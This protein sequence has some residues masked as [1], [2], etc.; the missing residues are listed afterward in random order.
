MNAITREEFPS[1]L[2]IAG[3]KLR[4]KR[5]L[6]FVPEK[7]EQWQDRDFIAVMN[8]SKTEGVIVAELDKMY[9][10]PFR[11]QKRT[12]NRMGRVEAI[13]CDICATWQR[14]STSAVISFSKEKGS[15]SFLCC[16]DLLCS[17]HV[18]DK[19]SVSKLSRVQLRETISPSQRIARLKER[20][21]SIFRE[22]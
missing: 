18:R 10:V 22:F 8:R 6:R 5:E 21:Q 11:L 16:G 1:L 12:A 19:T 17:L 14:G 9:V 15:V 20:L 7:I 4:L 13:I 2:E 3:I